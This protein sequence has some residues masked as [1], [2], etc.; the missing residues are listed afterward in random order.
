[1]P[2]R[3]VG[4]SCTITGIYLELNGGGAGGGRGGRGGIVGTVHIRP[5]EFHNSQESLVHTV[6]VNGVSQL[7]WLVARGYK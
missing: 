5:R 2:G 1:M 3:Y 7:I 4:T 6:K